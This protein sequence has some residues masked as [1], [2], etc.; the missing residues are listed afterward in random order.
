MYLAALKA[1]GL[2]P[3]LALKAKVIRAGEIQRK[4]AL[5]GLLISKGAREAIEAAGGSVE[6]PPEQPAPGRLKPKNAANTTAK[7][8]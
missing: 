3:H 5:K 1:A 8:E 7:A 2:V 4:L 6:A